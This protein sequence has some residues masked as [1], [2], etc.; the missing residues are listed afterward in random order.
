M[1]AP[2]VSSQKDG[3]YQ[4]GTVDELIWFAKQVNGGN[5]AISGALTADI[6][7]GGIN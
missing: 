3:V 1:K 2:A 7:L 6:D 4:I 5:T